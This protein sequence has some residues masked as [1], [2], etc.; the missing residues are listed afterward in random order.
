[1]IEPSTLLAFGLTAAVIVMSPGPDTVVI[2]RHALSAGR[3]EGLAAVLGV[4]LGLIIHTS[5]AALGISALIAASPALFRTL[6][7]AGALYLAWLGVRLLTAQG[8]AWI[9]TTPPTGAWR[10][11]REALLT[12]LLNPKVL[13]L[14]LALYPNFIVI[15]PGRPHRDADRLSLAGADRHQQR[16]AGRARLVGG[17]GATM[18]RPSRGGSPHPAVRRHCLYRVRPHPGDRACVLSAYPADG[19]IAKK[20]SRRWLSPAAPLVSLAVTHPLWT[21]GRSSGSAAPGGVTGC[22]NWRSIS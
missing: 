7:L 12:N 4:Q 21:S 19:G 17:P 18:V 1:M 13:V 5:L 11:G 15:D 8:P 9:R 6:S 16:L 22:A 14:F 20:K 2:V 3:S 10:A